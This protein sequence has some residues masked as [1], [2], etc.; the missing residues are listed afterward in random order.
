MFRNFIT[1]VYI[2]VSM[3][4]KWINRIYDGVED[5]TRKSQASFLIIQMLSEVL[6]R[7][8]LE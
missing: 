6:P 5:E 7:M 3:V 2:C 4:S 8:I 1:C